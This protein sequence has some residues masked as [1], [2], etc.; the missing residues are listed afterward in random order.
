MKVVRYG[1][2]ADMPALA[3]KQDETNGC[4]LMHAS[5]AAKIASQV[6]VCLQTEM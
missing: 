4:L 2:K 1:E 6:I 5:N 3:S